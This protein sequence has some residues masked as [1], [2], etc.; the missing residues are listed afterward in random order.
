MKIIKIQSIAKTKTHSQ[1][2]DNGNTANLWNTGINR[3]T[4]AKN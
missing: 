4:S 2:Q 1:T 3:M